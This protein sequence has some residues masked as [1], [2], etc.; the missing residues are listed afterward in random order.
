MTTS[1]N[2]THDPQLIATDL[3]TKLA[4]RSRHVCL[5]IGAGAG[6]S[7]GLP[8]M[9]KPKDLVL[10]AIDGEELKLSVPLL[11]TRNIEEA[12][13]RIRRIANLLGPRLNPAL[14][15][16]QDQLSTGE[17][18]AQGSARESSAKSKIVDETATKSVERRIGG[19]RKH[20][21][22]AFLI[23]AGFSADLGMPLVGELT[24]V[25]LAAFTEK[26]ARHLAEVLSGKQPFTK[27]RPINRKA[28]HEGMEMLLSYKSGGGA[29]YEELLKKL[30]HAGEVPGKTQSDRDSFDYL[31]SVF[32]GIIHMIL[33]EYQ[34]ESYRSLYPLNLQHFA[35]LRELVDA[36]GTWVF[37][38]NHDLYAECLA[39]DFGIPVT[40]G[41]TDDLEFPLNNLR[42]ADKIR[43]RYRPSEEFANQDVGWFKGT[44]GINLV[45]LHGGLAEQTYSDKA[46]TC[47]PMLSWSTSAELI[48][49]FGRIED[50]A[51][52][53]V[54]QKAPG[55]G[56]ARTI[57]GPD[58][59]LD[60]LSRSMLTGGKKYSQTTNEKKGEE[61]LKLLADVIRSSDEVV[62]IGYGF[63][64]AHINNRVLNAMVLNDRLR[65]S[66]IEPRHRPWPETW[67]EFLRQFDYN[68]R[69]A[70][71]TSGVA[72]WMPFIR[73]GKWDSAQI[74]ALKENRKL[75]T[76]IADRVRA[77]FQ[78]HS[79]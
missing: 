36:E 69:I 1:V 71:A 68:R 33:V 61:K 32:F 9:T 15:R 23:G 62:V 2:P 66:I 26:R 70:G 8:D 17:S 50:M 74:E 21:K 67:P 19:N 12:L 73:D 59:T 20:M 25:F 39:I 30:Q 44:R 13:T 37:S 42:P 51:F 3:N 49:E 14:S 7:A 77:K 56:S 41:D 64:D 55:G 57:T 65:M 79:R 52:F 24:E 34:N 46:L 4:A 60:I 5:L 53:H 22:R 48:R 28:I 38:L 47:N 54:G 43:F 58:G 6:L 76:V 31:F 18:Q 27:D 35:A 10:A 29:N 40:Y 78:G 16:T 11:K 72:E 63:G 75:R 45:R